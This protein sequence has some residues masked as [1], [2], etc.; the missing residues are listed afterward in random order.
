MAKLTDTLKTILSLLKENHITLSTYP[1][2]KEGVCYQFYC[3]TDDKIKG[4]YAFK[5]TIVNKNLL[6]AFRMQE[7]ISEALLT[8]GDEKNHSLL[9][10]E[11]NGGGFYYDNDLK[12]YKLSATY[13]VITKG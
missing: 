9:S 7:K 3:V 5:V 4:Q 13:A 1:L 8:K 2:T 11:V 10:C 6:D 12:M